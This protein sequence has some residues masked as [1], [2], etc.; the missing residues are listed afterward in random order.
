MSR[1]KQVRP[2]P[3]SQAPAETRAEVVTDARALTVR[4]WKTPMI[5]GVV[6]LI[7]IILFGVFGRD[8]ETSFA[9]STARDAVQLAPI[10][11]ST[12]VLGWAVTV[13]LL[14]LTAFS[15]WQVNLGRTT[16]FWAIVLFPL[17]AITGFLGWAASG[18]TLPVTGLLQGSLALAVPLVFG[19]LAGLL[20]ERVG[21][22]NIAIEGQL[23]AGAFFSAVTASITGNVWVGLFSAAIAGA[24]VSLILAVFSVKYLVNQVIVGVVLNVLI[25]GLTGFLFST[26]LKA[27]PSLNSPPRL[28]QISIPLLSEIP[29]LG[30][31]LFRQTVIVYIMYVAVA[32]V[33]VGLFHTRWGLRLRAVGEHPQAADTVGINVIR[34][35]YVNTMLGGLLAGLGGAF[36]TLGQV[37]AFGKDMTA[38][39]GYIA[40]AALIFGRWHPIYA[41]AAGLLFGF[42][43]NLQYVLGIIDSTLPSEFMLMLPYVVTIFAVAGLVGKVRAPAASGIPYVKS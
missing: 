43:T 26:V 20:S 24:L 38:G 27:N 33:Y 34:A 36:F 32:V 29:V 16:P 2:K 22:V 19:S 1:P 6:S 35:R 41:A 40:L 37:G 17:L 3:N 10:T 11:V 9:L 13:L 15:F 12:Q 14:A 18:A 42:A 25:S 5:F 30:P 23:L 31:L 4:S 28:E 7:Y 21:V 39:S 8:D